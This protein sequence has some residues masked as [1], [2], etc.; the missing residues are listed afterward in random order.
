MSF[1]GN[2][3]VNAMYVGGN[4]AVRAVSAFCYIFPD[5]CQSI[6]SFVTYEIPKMA[7]YG[8]PKMAVESAASATFWGARKIYNVGSGFAEWIH[9]VPP[10]PPVENPIKAGSSYLQNIPE[11]SNAQNILKAIG[12]EVQPTAENLIEPELSNLQKIYQEAALQANKLSLQS[13]S[14]VTGKTL[15]ELEK[16]ENSPEK[17]AEKIAAEKIGFSSTSFKAIDLIGPGLFL[18]LC[19][20]KALSNL[21]SALHHTKLLLTNQRMVSTAFQSPSLNSNTIA[22]VEKTRRYTAARLFRDAAMES[23]FTA[24]W[25]T[26]AYFTYYGIHDAVLEASGNNSMQAKFIANTIL[27]AGIVGPII[28]GWIEEALYMPSEAQYKSA[29]VAPH[30]VYPIEKDSGDVNRAETLSHEQKLE[31]LQKFRPVPAPAVPA[32]PAFDT[33]GE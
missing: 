12:L 31:Y 6:S 23:I 15:E 19:A 18:S 21:S 13:T 26:G 28:Y 20:N 29:P 11:V 33:Q 30:F 17:I 9:P 2:L 8:L 16:L 7:A 5:Q 14:W 1:G 4:L 27:T 10:I 3:A 22:I 24:L 25:S 32:V